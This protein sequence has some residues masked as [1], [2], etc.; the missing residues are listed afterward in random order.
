MGRILRQISMLIGDSNRAKIVISINIEPRLDGMPRSGRE[1]K[2]PVVAV[3][4]STKTN[5]SR[6]AWPSIVMIAWRQWRQPSMR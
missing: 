4:W 3:Y 2:D 5:P 1:D 6:V